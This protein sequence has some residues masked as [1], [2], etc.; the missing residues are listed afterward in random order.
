MVVMP[1]S[2]EGPEHKI[3]Q[4]LLSRFS[5]GENRLGSTEEQNA[6]FHLMD[7]AFGFKRIDPFRN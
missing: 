6:I 3:N 5:F 2:E 7:Y 4:K 1:N